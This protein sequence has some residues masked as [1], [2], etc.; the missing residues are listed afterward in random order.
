MQ[1]GKGHCDSC[2]KQFDYYLIHNGFNESAYAYCDKSGEVCLLDLW[3]MP[4]G[5]DIIGQGLIPESVEPFLKPCE[6]GGSFKREAAPRCPSCNSILS[7]LTG[8]KYLEANAKGTQAGWRWQ[9]SWQGLYCIVI[10][11]RLYKDCWKSQLK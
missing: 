5:V 9:Q 3:R 7:A 6:C 4:A 8:T 1:D 10:A 2:H 11:G